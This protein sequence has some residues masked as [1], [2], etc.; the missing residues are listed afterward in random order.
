MFVLYARIGQRGLNTKR[1]MIGFF[2]VPR[3]LS[4]H[5]I[6]QDRTGETVL[7]KRR[8]MGGEGVK[9][10]ENK[11]HWPRWIG[12][13]KDEGWPPLKTDGHVSYRCS[14]YQVPSLTENVRFYIYMN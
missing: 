12:G 9:T 2:W 7:V 8:E 4:H 5:M 3:N 6:R 1:P 14:T 10:T 11:I 13:L